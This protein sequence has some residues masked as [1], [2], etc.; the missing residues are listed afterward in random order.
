MMFLELI[1][2]R[3]FPV[4]AIAIAAYAKGAGDLQALK[5]A[6]MAK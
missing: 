6:R 2:E 1:R 3:F 4:I 5:R